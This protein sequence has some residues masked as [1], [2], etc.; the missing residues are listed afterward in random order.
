[1]G[2]KNREGLLHSEKKN[3]IP[4][5]MDFRVKRSEFRCML[6]VLTYTL[7]KTPYSWS[8]LNFLICKIGTIAKSRIFLI[9]LL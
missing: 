2:M 7:G 4:K 3:V 1:M 5:T 9:A 6:S 8:S